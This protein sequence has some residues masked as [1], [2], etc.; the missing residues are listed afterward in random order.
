MYFDL[1][2][3]LLNLK[4]GVRPLLSTENGSD[5]RNMALA[6]E[7]RRE[8]EREREREIERGRRERES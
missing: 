8:R 3:G 7:E 1:R 4:V 5:S 6:W 2:K